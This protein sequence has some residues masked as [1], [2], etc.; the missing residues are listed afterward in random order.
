MSGSGGGF[1]GKRI[2]RVA[3]ALVLGSLLSAGAAELGLRFLLFGQSPLAKRL[4][5]RWRRAEWYADSKSEDAY[6]RLQD[7]FLDPAQ[8]WSTPAPDPVCGWTGPIAPGTYLPTEPVDLRG[9][10]PVLLYGDSYAM[11]VT[12][13]EQ[14]FQALLEQS[15]LADRYC[16]VN[17][18][19]G[20]YGLDQ[21]YL[22]L[23]QSIDRWKELDPIVVVSFLVDDDFCRTVL[24][25]RNWPK[26]GFRI[27]GDRLVSDGP[28][29]VDLDEFRE[30]NPIGIRSYLW[31]FVVFRGSFLPGAM[32]NLLR[33]PYSRRTEQAALARRLLEEIDRELASRGLDHFYLVFHGAD[34]LPEPSLT[35]WAEDL[36]DEMVKE[37]AIPA[38]GTRPFLLAAAGGDVAR[39]REHLFLGAFYGHYNEIGNVAA[40]EALRQGLEGR[41][42]PVDPSRVAGMLDRFPYGEADRRPSTTLLGRPAR[43]R[44]R[45]PTAFAREGR[46]PYPP[47]ESG[48][49]ETYLVVGP[50]EE[51]ATEVHMTIPA[52]S[53]RFRAR[54]ISV[55]RGRPGEAGSPLTLSISVDGRPLRRDVVPPWPE[56][57]DLDLDLRGGTALELAVEPGGGDAWIHLA[58]ARFERSP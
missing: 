17:Y 51:G 53:P 30:R 21:I 24:R 38:I 9:R 58:G 13:R 29:Q 37:L 32:R 45:G 39:A 4:G 33:A 31:R 43:I 15:D 11:C 1:R 22:L 19:V 20:G 16:L 12:P 44:T 26:P 46:T 56:G 47:F 41:F 14:C 34:S 40:F 52:L 18:G 50:G 35:G 8:R 3:A 48:S 27:E 5:T 7:L 54:A 6:W 55:R 36:A 49:G 2:R 10:R 57:V 28:V 42:D 25:F 23:Q